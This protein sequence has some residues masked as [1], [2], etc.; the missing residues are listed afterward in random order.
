MVSIVVQN[1]IE[2]DAVVSIT[3]NFQYFARL[4]WKRLFTPQKMG[5][6]GYFTPKMGNNVNETPRRHIPARIRVVW[7]IKRENPS[8]RLTCRWVHEKKGINKKNSLYFTH[9][10]RS[11]PWTDLHQ[12]WRSCTGRRHNHLYQ[13]ICWSVKGCGFC[14]GSK[15][16]IS[17]WQSQSPLTQGWR[18]RT[19]RD[20]PVSVCLCLSQVGVLS[21]RLHYVQLIRDVIIITYIFLS[22]PEQT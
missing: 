2:I 16:A 22:N 12:I 15:I 13:I 7:A 21:K 9:L 11:P 8:S 3:W 20:D 17:H 1:L 18:Y 19:V 10:P 5:V 6:L 14:G 4:V